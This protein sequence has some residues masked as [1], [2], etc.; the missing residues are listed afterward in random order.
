MP[1]SLPFSQL[2]HKQ[3]GTI[4][5]A[6][7]LAAM[8]DVHSVSGPLRQPSLLAGCIATQGC[9][10]CPLACLPPAAQPLHMLSHPQHH[11]CRLVSLLAPA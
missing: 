7:W 8:T 2:D 10:A 11:R 9:P 4:D 1:A 3:A 5:L 6:E